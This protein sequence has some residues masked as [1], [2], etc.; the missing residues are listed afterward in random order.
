MS[1]GVQLVCLGTG[2]PDLEVRGWG[3]VCVCGVVWFEVVRLQLVSGLRSATAM[4]L[5]VLLNPAY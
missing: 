3:G 5:L 4:L 1:Q 2:T